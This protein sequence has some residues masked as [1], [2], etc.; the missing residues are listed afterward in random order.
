MLS[1][2]LL[3]RPEK[4]TTRMLDWYETFFLYVI[5]HV[6]ATDTVMPYVIP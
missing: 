1:I 3:G 6:Y 2:S 5:L 4:Y